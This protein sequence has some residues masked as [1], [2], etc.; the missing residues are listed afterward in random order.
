VVSVRGSGN[1]TRQL[2][3]QCVQAEMFVY[4]H[5]CISLA[6]FFAPLSS[7]DALRV[8]N[9]TSYVRCAVFSCKSHAHRSTVAHSKSKPLH[10]FHSTTC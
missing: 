1:S 4:C 10:V 9:V 3:A 5:T 2:G 8:N 6:Y 7:Q